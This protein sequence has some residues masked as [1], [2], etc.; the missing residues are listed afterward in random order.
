MTP[1]YGNAVNFPMALPSTNSPIYIAPGDGFMSFWTN[2]GASIGD[3]LEIN[4]GLN[5]LGQV[6]YQNVNGPMNFIFPVSKGD[7]FRIV[8][9]SN[10]TSSGRFITARF[11]PLKRVTYQS[12]AEVLDAESFRGE[13]GPPSDTGWAPEW[14]DHFLIATMLACSEYRPVP[15]AN[16]TRAGS[17]WTAPDNGFVRLHVYGRNNGWYWMTVNEANV[18]NTGVNTVW[19]AGLTGNT[20]ATSQIIPVCKGDVLLV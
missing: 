7:R 14:A 13:Q 8:S 15:A 16:A 6:A 18:N 9:A 1:Y 10:P 12:L 20:A 17:P 4:E 2:P 3:Y 11:I 5:S 19:F